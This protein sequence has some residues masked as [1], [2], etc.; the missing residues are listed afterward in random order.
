MESATWK[1]LSV[2]ARASESVS[3]RRQLMLIVLLLAAFSF[4]QWGCGPSIAGRPNLVLIISDD[5]GYPDFGFMGSEHVATPELDRLAAE[6]TVFRNAYLTSSICGPSLQSLLTGLNPFE[7]NVRLIGLRQR[8]IVRGSKSALQD[9]STLPRLLG[10]RGYATFQGGKIVETDHEIAGFS[11]GISHLAGETATWAGA[12]MI[13]RSTMQPIYDF[14]DDN[15]DNPFFLWFAPLLPHL[16]HDAPARYRAAFEG[17]GYS[18][19]A[20]AYYANIARFDEAVGQLIQHLEEQG[21]RENTL[22]VFLSDNGWDQGPFAP[23]G[24]IGLG[25][26]MGKKSMYELGFRTPIVFNW[27]GQVPAGVVHDDLV[28]SIDLYPTFLDYAGVP[29]MS[30]RHGE[31]L[32]SVIEGRGKWKREHLLGSM[33]HVRDH[34]LRPAGLG[35]VSLTRPE[36]SYFVRSE[37]WHYIWHKDWGADELFD[38]HVDPE[39][40]LDVAFRHPRLVTMFRKEILEWQ[41]QM[42]ERPKGEVGPRS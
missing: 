36:F 23:R 12:G 2:R 42:W 35:E 17:K 31:S 4:P 16:P 34:V 13:A 33:V 9:F 41:Q 10:R 14:I 15:A 37:R 28:S 6:G 39:E 25:G 7:Y 19:A 20:I 1:A 8:G 18:P 22:I 27:S 38:L 11:D 40:N 5:Q 29:A 3:Q 24:A 30:G 21:L 32:R 26:K